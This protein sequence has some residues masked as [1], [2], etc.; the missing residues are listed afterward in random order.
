MPGVDRALRVPPNCRGGEDR[1]QAC[2]DSDVCLSWQGLAPV[3]GV[4]RGQSD[5]NADGLVGRDDGIDHRRSDAGGTVER[6]LG[7]HPLG[8]RW[9]SCRECE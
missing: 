4:I 8:I 5:T 7:R 6:W 9:R 2:A 1:E 3:G